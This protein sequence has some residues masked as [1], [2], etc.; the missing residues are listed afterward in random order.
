MCLAQASSFPTRNRL[1]LNL[2]AFKR[3]KR[4]KDFGEYG[5][6]NNVKLENWQLQSKHGFGPGYNTVYPR[7]SDQKRVI[8]TLQAG[9]LPLV[10][11]QKT[12][13]PYLRNV[14]IPR[15]L[16]NYNPETRKYYKLDSALLGPK[17]RLKNE[18]I[19]RKIKYE[20]R[21]D[22]FKY[23]GA[24]FSDKLVTSAGEWNGQTAFYLR[25]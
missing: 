1:F 19:V 24:F 13:K 8:L 12:I 9:A 22:D 4:H 3:V 25:L 18:G 16:L 17:Y 11:V 10:E 23:P 2:T 7:F 15:S 14:E 21:Y 6:A 5:Q 20:R